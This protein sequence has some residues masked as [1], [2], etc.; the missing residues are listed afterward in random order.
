MGARWSQNPTQDIMS[1]NNLGALAMLFP[2]SD[3]ILNFQRYQQNFESLPISDTN[4][5]NK[6]FSANDEKRVKI[7]LDYWNEGLNL[8]VKSNEVLLYFS[9]FLIS[10]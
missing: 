7:A 1:M 4:Q 2:S 10:T 6:L 9:S 8:A 3:E 5:P